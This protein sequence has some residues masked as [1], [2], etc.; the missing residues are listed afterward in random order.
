MK[1]AKVFVIIGAVLLFWAVASWIATKPVVV[2]GNVT[3]V[4]DYNT[5]QLVSV[6]TTKDS[7]PELID[8]VYNFKIRGVEKLSKGDGVKLFLRNGLFI[9]DVTIYR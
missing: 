9:R 8:V 2:F 6:D 7:K 5:Y 1:A 4:T 3:S